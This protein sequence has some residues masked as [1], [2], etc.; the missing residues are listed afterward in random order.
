MRWPNVTKLAVRYLYAATGVRTVTTLPSNLVD[1]LPVHRITR[2]PGGDDKITDSPL[3]DVETFA[4][5]EDQ[6]W[7]AAE[8]ARQA[9]HALAGLVV[10]GALVDTVTT[11]TSATYVDYGNPKVYRAV[12]SYRLA[13][14]KR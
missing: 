2:G 6:M 1:I 10:D 12:A 5:S 13:L 14:R 7:E 11:A 9:M 4:A 3:V 8:D